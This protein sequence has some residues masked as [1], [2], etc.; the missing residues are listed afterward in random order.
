M[1]EP[2]SDMAHVPIELLKILHMYSI[3]GTF[4]QDNS[5]ANR[6]VLKIT[7][8]TQS[9]TMALRYHILSDPGENI[10]K[11]SLRRRIQP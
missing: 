1:Y 11:D 10:R 4:K 9:A 3:T 2:C 6:T 8:L 5:V 7:C